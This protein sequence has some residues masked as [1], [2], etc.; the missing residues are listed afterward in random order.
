MA[1]QGHYSR[2]S[3]KQD[4]LRENE[5]REESAMT[6][7]KTETFIGRNVKLVTFLVCLGLFLA[8]FGPWSIWRIHEWQTQ[9]AQEREI[10]ATAFSEEDLRDLI[11][12]GARLTWAD[13]AG[14]YYEAIWESGMCIREYAVRGDEFSLM[15]S[16]SSDSAALDS[17]L[18]IRQSDHASVD[19]LS[20][21]AE[22]AAG[23]L[24]K[25]N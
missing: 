3:E 13:F 11:D 25:N 17:V 10:A 4:P 14:H 20:E 15:V 21:S 1:Y 19:L 12:Q 22:D 24:T 23:L 18:L 5:K 2:K 9:R 8:L 16:A 6:V 7:G